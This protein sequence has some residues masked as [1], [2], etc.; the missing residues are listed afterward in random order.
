MEGQP[1]RQF[2]TAVLCA[3]LVTGVCATTNAQRGRANKSQFKKGD[4]VE[5]RDGFDWKPGTVESVEDFSGWVTVRPDLPPEVGQ[6]R[7]KLPTEKVPPSDVRASKVKAPKKSTAPSTPLRKWSDKSGKFSIEARYQERSGDRVALLKADGKRVEVP[8]AKLSDEDTK[9]LQELNNASDSP[10]EEVPDAQSAGAP[11]TTAGKKANWNGARLIQPKTFPKWS[12]TPQPSQATK[13]SPVNRANL[14]IALN[15]IPDS[16]VFFE[17]V[18]G[19]YPSLDGSKVVLVRTKGEV[20][21]DKVGYLEVVD[22]AKQDAG[23]LTQLPDTT[24]VL[25]VLPD[26]NLVLLRPN[27][28]GSGENGMLT[29]AR[30][31]GGTVTP[32]HQW[33]PYAD[34]DFAPSRDIDKA[35]FLNENRVMTINGHGKALTIWDVA[36]TKALINVPV[37]VSFSL[38]LA[39]SPDR[40]FLA[41]VMKDGIAMI[42]LAAGSHVAT[43]PTNGRKFQKVAIRG[44]NTRLAGLSNEGVSVWNLAS[45]ELMSEFYSASGGGVVSLDWVGDYV[46]ANSR[47]LFDVDR[48]ILLWEYENPPGVGVTAKLQNGQLYAVAKPIGDQG[49]IT[50]VSASLPSAAAVEKAASLPPA[51]ELLVVK[52]GDSVSLDVDIDPSVSLTEAVQKALKAKAGDG[53][54]ADIE[55]IVVLNPHGTQNDLI[56]GLLTKALESAGLKVVEKSDLVVKAVCKPQP[57]Q[58]LKIRVDNRFPPR[59]DDIEE[60]TITPYATYLE[61]SLKGETLWK[62]GFVAM[63]HMV[64]WKEPGES[65]DQALER[66]TKPNV[67]LLTNARFIPYV[68]RPGK[69]TPN[70][71]YGVSQFT[72]RGIVD[73]RGESE[74]AS[75]SFE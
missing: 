45:G 50:L 31:E 72:A 48:R 8:V 42:D 61:M 51:T 59:P 53:A 26:A 2:L 57:S 20:S 6:F 16:Q 55:K 49:K 13:S 36:H 9:Y 12:F 65:L 17:S 62:R 43:I 19:I 75:G 21:R 47:N 5:F 4:P 18:L 70:G 37:G 27:V 3:S 56:R 58:V 24:L 7:G 23:A 35:W 32:V 38:E 66:M 46:L 22:T 60:R 10:F 68:A 15:D 44:D 25:D 29:L 67:T 63:P 71:A 64:V 74:S 52:P 73:K 34:E 39:L 40:Q 14:N 33:E 41:V 11:P 54:D 30:Y 28:F 1:I 69:A